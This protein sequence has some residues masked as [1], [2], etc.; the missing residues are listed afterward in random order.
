MPSAYDNNEVP[1]D[2]PLETL[3]N[4]MMNY[5][6]SFH[7]DQQQYANLSTN[8]LLT[9]NVSNLTT[10]DYR[11]ARL[12]H[13]L[14][15]SQDSAWYVSET[16]SLER[17]PSPDE[18]GATEGQKTWYDYAGKS[19]GNEREGTNSVPGVIAQVLP[20]GSTQYTYYE[21]N[22]WRLPIAEVSTY[23]S[24]GSIL[25]RTNTIEYYDN[26]LDV[27]KVSDALG[28]I[29]G[30]SYTNHQ[31]LT[32][33]NGL[34]EVTTCTYDSLGR[35]TSVT[36]PNGLVSS[37][38]FCPSGTYSNWLEK[39]I[40]YA[41]IGGSAL[42]TNEFTYTNGLFYT[43]KD[44]RGLTI[45]NTYDALERLTSV[46]YPD[47]SY[48]SNVFD[49]LDLAATKDRLGNW[50]Y[51]GYNAVRQLTAETN[52]NNAVTRYVYCACG[53]PEYITNL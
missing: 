25:T 14:L 5:R 37:N 8:Y 15:R 38:C 6:N 30:Y 45:T 2:T 13:W 28:L 26:H 21:L 20:D 42:R 53:S 11:K 48:V 44:A 32:F 47:G 34:T 40:D 52:A 23:S 17:E 9:K 7:W 39:T 31:V 4:T 49:K 19:G 24:G 50:T 46:R 51:Y 12:K 27:K 10:N 41:S 43:F 33:T 35:L 18:D 3:D 16:L 29:A 36:Q 22:E 1:D